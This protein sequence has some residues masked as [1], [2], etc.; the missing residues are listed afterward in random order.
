MNKLK[1]IDFKESFSKIKRDK[2]T[3]M[4]AGGPIFLQPDEETRLKKL[5]NLDNSCQ[6][7][8]EKIHD[9]LLKAWEKT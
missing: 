6:E 7:A 9:G 5:I 1:T 8:K 2:D 3:Y 4:T